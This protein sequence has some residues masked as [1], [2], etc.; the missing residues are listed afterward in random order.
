M[1]NWVI[2]ALIVVVFFF[3]ARKAFGDIRKGKCAGCSCDSKKKAKAVN[4][5]TEHACCTTDGSCGCG[6]KK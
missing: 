1:V 2:I 5:E 6:G 4:I 3:A